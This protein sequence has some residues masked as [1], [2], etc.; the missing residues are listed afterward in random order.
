MSGCPSSDVISGDDS[1]KAVPGNV[2]VHLGVR[3]VPAAAAR[4]GRVAAVTAV[5]AS[6]R[7]ATTA[8]SRRVG[9]WA[10]GTRLLGGQRAGMARLARD[11]QMAGIVPWIGAEP[12]PARR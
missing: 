9:K 8:I 4:V 2:R 5:A 3:V 10:M 1:R 7:A 6:A 12:T 11:S